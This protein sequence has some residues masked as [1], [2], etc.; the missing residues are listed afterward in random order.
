VQ[1]YEKV[2]FDILLKSP[3][4]KWQGNGRKSYVVA[5]ILKVLQILPKF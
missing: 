2:H 4:L 3:I 1:L 5:S